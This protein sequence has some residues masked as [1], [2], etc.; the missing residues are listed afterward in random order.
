MSIKNI[1]PDYGNQFFIFFYI[2]TFSAFMK[3]NI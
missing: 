2:V 3:F 1:N